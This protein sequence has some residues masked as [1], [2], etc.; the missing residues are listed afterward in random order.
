VNTLSNTVKKAKTTQYCVYILVI[1]IG[2][3]FR[4]IYREP[5]SVVRFSSTEQS[6]QRVVPWKNKSRK[7]GEELT[8]D[9]EEDEKEVECNNTQESVDLGNVALLLEVV[10]GWVLGELMPPLV[11]RFI[12]RHSSGTSVTARTDSS[13]M[14]SI[15]QV[16]SMREPTSLS[17]WAM[18][19]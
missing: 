19:P 2:Y 5:L 3:Y 18:V 14:G 1:A 17:I 6:F 8:S 7:V 13:S 12:H 10:Q 16:R 4:V 15:F 9:V 11:K